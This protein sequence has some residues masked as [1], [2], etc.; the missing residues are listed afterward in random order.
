MRP[1]S[2][3]DCTSE[4]R[5]AW[6][7]YSTLPMPTPRRRESRGSTARWRQSKHLLGVP[8]L[9]AKVQRCEDRWGCQP[10][11]IPKTSKGKHKS[12]Q[13][14]W[15]IIAMV[16]INIDGSA[17]SVGPKKLQTESLRISIAVFV[18]VDN[19]KKYR[20]SSSK[21]KAVLFKNQGRLLQK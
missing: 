4:H 21:I 20:R 6:S 1:Q 18:C 7:G 8:Q 9:S 13:T 12:K 10:R 16:E 19:N 2:H 5:H 11:Q 15:S 3:I 17:A 14:S